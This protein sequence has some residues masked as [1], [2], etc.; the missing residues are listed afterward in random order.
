MRAHTVGDGLDQVG[1]LALAGSISRRHHRGVD[2]EDVVAVDPD[3]GKSVAAGS[4]GDGAGGLLRE[5]HRDRPAVVLT[6]KD[7]RRLEDPGEVH[8]LVPVAL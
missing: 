5:R 7:D 4:V 3:A 1:A 8:R 2:P 6:E